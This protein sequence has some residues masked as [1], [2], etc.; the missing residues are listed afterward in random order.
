LGLS[1][2]EKPFEPNNLPLAAVTYDPW[3]TLFI[4]LGVFPAPIPESVS[5]EAVIKVVP[6]QDFVT[7][8]VSQEEAVIAFHQR[9]YGVKH[10]AVTAFKPT[11]GEY[12]IVFAV[13]MRVPPDLAVEFFDADLSAEVT[14]RT[15]Y[16]VRFRV[17]GRGGYKKEWV[18]IKGF[19]LDAEL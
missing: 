17:K 10:Q 18:P 15:T 14:Y 13:P 1:T 9:K 19:T 12:R 5:N 6:D 3:F 8:R 7:E 16:E 11:S 2:L 4:S